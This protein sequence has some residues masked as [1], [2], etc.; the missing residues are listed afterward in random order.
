MFTVVDKFNRNV[1]KVIC[2]VAWLGVAALLLCLA[3]FMYHMTY[4]VAY[5][6]F[7][8]FVTTFLLGSVMCACTLLLISLVRGSKL[9]SRLSKIHNDGIDAIRA[10]DGGSYV[11]GEG[12]TT[13]RFSPPVVVSNNVDKLTLVINQYTSKL[14]VPATAQILVTKLGGITTQKSRI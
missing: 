3:L 2:A 8:C 1:H 5:N 10:Y 6:P 11:F 13:V 14:L 7:L 4:H 12:E 9:S